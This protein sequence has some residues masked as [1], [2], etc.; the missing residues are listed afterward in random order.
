MQVPVGKT[1]RELMVMHESKPFNYMYIIKRL[2]EMFVEVHEVASEI[3]K[4]FLEQKNKAAYMAISPVV[5]GLGLKIMI[6]GNFL[7]YQYEHVFQFNDDF[8]FTVKPIF[9]DKA[10]YKQYL[11]TSKINLFMSATVSKDFLV[12]TIG[13]EDSETKEI[14]LDPVFDPE[15]KPFIFV[16]PISLNY[17]SLQKI[18]T[19]EHLNRVIK[20]LVDHH[21]EDAGI[22]L[23]PSFK[24]SNLLAEPLIKSGK[25]VI[26]QKSGQQV[27]QVIEL[28]RSEVDKG[29]L[30][31]LISPS[32]FEGINLED[33]YC[34][35]QILT[36]A[37]F[38]SLADERIR[39]IMNEHPNIFDIMTIMKLVQGAGRGVRN[40]DDYCATYALDSNIKRLFLSK[41]NIWLDEF[42]VEE[43]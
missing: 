4:D 5:R 20:N 26:V 27:S 22:I 23:T 12:E 2:L 28:Y 35:F 37:P 9:I 16:R 32:L 31:I 7:D 29:K 25:N 3:A 42:S 6:F 34:R 38:G 13:L 18:Q 33:D 21:A 14:V 15:N 8:G 1:G 43:Y 40:K 19:I 36:K 17:N 39:Y 10:I 24:L 11:D 30:P 41:A